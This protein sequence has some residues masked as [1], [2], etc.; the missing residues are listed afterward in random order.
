MRIR[1]ISRD[2]TTHIE[3]SRRWKCISLRNHIC[4]HGKTLSSGRDVHW[5]LRCCTQSSGRHGRRARRVSA[6][7]DVST[8]ASATCHDKMRSGCHGGCIW[9]HLDAAARLL[10]VF[11]SLRPSKHFFAA[12]ITST[13]NKNCPTVE[14]GICKI[15][16][17][18]CTLVIINK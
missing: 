8:S 3:D 13:S 11:L 18:V 6:L 12:K 9:Q 4:N 14:R 7:R 10:G 2:R 15:C 5:R 16:N 1:T 17:K